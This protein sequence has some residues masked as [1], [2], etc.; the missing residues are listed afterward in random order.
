VGIHLLANALAAV[1]ISIYYLSTFNTDFIL[2][3]EHKAEDAV[4]CLNLFNV[5][6]EQ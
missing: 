3:P 6:T 4:A 5:I 2:V 1:N